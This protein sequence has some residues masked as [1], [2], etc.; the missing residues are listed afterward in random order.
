[1]DYR[2]SLQECAMSN[3]YAPPKAVVHDVISADQGVVAADRG[4]RLGASILD[5]LIFTL[6]VYLP[7]VVGVMLGGVS[8]DADNSTAALTGGVVAFVGLIVWCWLTFRSIA[9]TGQSLAK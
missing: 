1:V 3:P 4:T 6:M 5:G 8:G 7:F 9:R 2:F